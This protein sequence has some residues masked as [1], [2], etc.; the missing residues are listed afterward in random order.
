[1]RL[2]VH[3]WNGVDCWLAWCRPAHHCWR[4]NMI[5]GPCGVSKR[6]AAGKTIFLFY[7]ML[8]PATATRKS[9]K[10]CC[11]MPGCNTS[12]KWKWKSDHCRQNWHYTTMA[13]RLTTEN[14]KPLVTRMKLPLTL[15]FAIA[16][17][18]SSLV[19]ADDDNDGKSKKPPPKMPPDFQVRWIFFLCS[20]L[21][22]TP[23]VDLNL[24]LIY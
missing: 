24:V 11:E 10:S 4:H 19:R 1:M 5:D 6:E 15:L 9:K 18:A 16:I 22:A 14:C 8:H 23:A 3:V 20:H 21:R 2:R 7:L 12:R 17:A 13:S